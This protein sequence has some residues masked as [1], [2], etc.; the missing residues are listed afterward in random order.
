MRH[1]VKS[2]RAVLPRKLQLLKDDKEPGSD[3]LLLKW[4]HDQMVG[5]S[6]AHFNGGLEPDVFEVE[7]SDLSEVLQVAN[8]F[9]SSI[10]RRLNA[11]G[12]QDTPKDEFARFS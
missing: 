10:R 3:K 7:K 4:L 2:G 6:E 12:D 8:L 1:E 5:A 9:T 11:T